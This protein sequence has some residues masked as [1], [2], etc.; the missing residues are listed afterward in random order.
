[1]RRILSD[2]MAGAS[3]F[4]ARARSGPLTVSVLAPS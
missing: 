2:L 3:L 1:M 4:D